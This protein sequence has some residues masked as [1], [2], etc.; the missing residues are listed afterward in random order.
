[1]DNYNYPLGADNSRA[2]WNNPDN[3]E[4]EIEVCVSIT[5]SKSFKIKVSD[6]EIEYNK[7][8]DGDHYDIIFDNCDLKQAVKEQI[9]LPH[10]AYKTILS[11]TER[12]KK[13]YEDIKGWNV[14]DY[15]VILE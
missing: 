10:E 9:T 14:D 3:P 15:E 5:L 12:S 11:N 8:E 6:Y 1:M 7:D 2:P 13:V 4:E